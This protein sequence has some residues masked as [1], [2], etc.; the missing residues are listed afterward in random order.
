MCLHVVKK[1]IKWPKS[2]YKVFW[3]RFSHSFGDLKG[4]Y[5]SSYHYNQGWNYPTTLKVDHNYN[6]ISGG[7]L[8][9][10]V[11]KPQ[12]DYTPK[13]YPVICHK[14]DLIAFGDDNDAAFKKI[15]IPKNIV[16]LT[17]A[18]NLIQKEL[19]NLCL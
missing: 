17:S 16:N 15:Y 9:V 12:R 8:H 14:N 4:Y 10:T 2:G 19:K 6:I 5:Q 18:T 3:K 13:Y 1:K 11:Q 7:C